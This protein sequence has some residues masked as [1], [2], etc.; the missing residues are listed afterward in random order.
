MK[1]AVI[2]SGS[3]GNCVVLG[4]KKTGYWLVDAGLSAKQIRVRLEAIGVSLSCLRGIFLTHEHKDHIGG[5]KVLLKKLSVPVYASVMTQEYL[6]S[7]LQ[8]EARWILFEPGQRFLVGPLEVD[9]VRI[10]HDATDPVGFIFHY[11]QRRMAVMTD[12]GYAS[13]SLI[14]Q[15]KGVEVLY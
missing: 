13:E 1:L 15:L 7:Q 6:V 8:L 3:A 2:G 12:L 14:E 9:A 4:S 10:P 11:E 5:L